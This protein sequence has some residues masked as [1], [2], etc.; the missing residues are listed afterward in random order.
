MHPTPASRGTGSSKGRLMSRFHL[1]KSHV[2]AHAC[3][4]PHTHSHMNTH[5]QCSHTHAHACTCVLTRTRAHTHTHTLR[6]LQVSR[7]GRAWEASRELSGRRERGSGGWS[8]TPWSQHGHPSCLRFLSVAET[9]D[10]PGHQ[11]TSS[12]GSPVSGMCVSVH[13][14]PPFC[15]SCLRQGWAR[16]RSRFP[17]APLRNPQSQ[18]WGAHGAR[19]PRPVVHSAVPWER[20]RLRAGCGAAPG[21][22]QS[23]AGRLGKKQSKTTVHLL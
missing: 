20:P 9:L 11:P 10:R 14:G 5:M 15:W 17:V 1:Q 23:C 19:R 16:G 22:R 13:P 18:K 4:R 21:P 2:H 6:S 12:R 8:E 7:P 3:T